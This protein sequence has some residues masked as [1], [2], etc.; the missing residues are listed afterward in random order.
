MA[1]KKPRLEVTSESPTGLNKRFLDTQTGK[2]LTRGQ[3]ADAIERGEYPG[4]HV[5]VDLENRRIPRSNPDRS[6]AN[7][8]D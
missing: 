1:K 3:L 8:L 7:N 6:K 4:Y 2:E 5:M